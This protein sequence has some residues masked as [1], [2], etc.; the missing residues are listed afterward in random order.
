MVAKM[1]PTSPRGSMPRPISHLSL[2]LPNAPKAATSLPMT[3]TTRRIVASF[4]TGTEKKAPTSASM[5]ICR[6]NTG[7]NRCP[8]GASSRLMR[9]AALTRLR[10]IP[11]TK[12]PTIGANWAA[13]AR[14]AKPKAKAKAMAT[15]V[16]VVRGEALDEVEQRPRQLQAGQPAE[17]QEGHGD[18]DD[19]H[20]RQERD[21][22]LGH[23]TDNHRQHD[24][25]HDVVGHRGA[26]HQSGLGGGE[27]SQVP[28]HPR[29]DADARRRQRRGHEEL[30]VEVVGDRTHGEETQDHRGDHTDDGHLKGGPTDLAQLGQVHLHA[31]L[32]QE[33][34]DPHL[35]EGHQHLVAVADE[36]EH[37]RADDDAGHDLADHG[38][39]A[40]ALGDL[41]RRF[42]RDEHD[43]DVGEELSEVH[44]SWCAGF[45]LHA[46]DGAT[47]E[48]GKT[49]ECH[50][51]ERPSARALHTRV[52]NLT[53]F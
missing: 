50:V 33:E 2:R 48:G 37:G 15:S 6:K 16:P 21:R 45:L 32:E 8:T 34:D 24:E 5:P 49:D 46:S 41:R 4:S 29:R 31:D 30:R 42:G 9:G 27:G 14:R 10:A 39:D 51:R 3:A 25:A 40:D 12:A 35:A 53:S 52:A 1:R 7:M 28:E 43:Q 19:P 23:E 22:A 26:E 36:A 18:A 13:S 20:H 47:Y 44:G 11:A 38:R 17:D